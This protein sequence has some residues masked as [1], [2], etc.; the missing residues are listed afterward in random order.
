MNSLEI[1][2]E[3]LLAHNERPNH[4]YALQH[5]TH[6]SDG[7]NPLCGDEVTA[8]LQ[9]ENN[10]VK[11]V[12]FT[13]QGCAVCKASASLMT[14]RL[15]G[16]SV[17]EAEADAKSVLAWLKDASAEPPSDLGELEAL[18]GVRKFPMRLKCATLAWHAFLKALNQPSNSD[19]GKG[20]ACGCCGGKNTSDGGKMPNGNRPSNGDC[21]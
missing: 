7:R 4:F 2:R 8:Y 6:R 5:P 15:P 16:K 17:S 10:I 13:G 9:V 3:T 1:Y 19:A 20:N 11:D 18:T 14:S 21:C 12:S